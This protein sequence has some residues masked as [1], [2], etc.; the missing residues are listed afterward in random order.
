MHK[1][2]H[3]CKVHHFADDTNLL[4]SHKDPQTICK[5]MN[6]ELTLLFEWLCAIRLS[7][8]VAKTEFIIFRPQ[9]KG[10][11]DRVVLELNKTKIHESTKIRYLGLILDRRLT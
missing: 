7:L 1:A 4:F 3:K 8:N 2:F 5:V 10:L 11:S 9:M 6:K